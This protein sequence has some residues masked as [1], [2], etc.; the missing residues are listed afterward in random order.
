MSERIEIRLNDEKRKL[1]N[2]GDTIRFLKEPELE[3]SFLVKEIMNG[4]L[5]IKL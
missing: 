1:I 3:E 2:I 4:L 5:I